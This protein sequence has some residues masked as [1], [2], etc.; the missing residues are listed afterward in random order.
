MAAPRLLPPEPRLFVDRVDEFVALDQALGDALERG[1]PLLAVRTGLPGVGKTTLAVKWAYHVRDRFPDGQLYYELGGSVEPGPVPASDVLRDILVQLGVDEER[2]PHHEHER[3]AVV[4]SLT[5]DKRILLVLDDAFSAAQVMALLPSS[6][7]C[8]VVVTSRKWLDDPAWAYVDRAVLEP[9]AAEFATELLNEASGLDL[10]AEE[11][12][13]KRLVSACAG[14]PLALEVVAG[15][16]RRPRRRIADVVEAVLA[17]KGAVASIE[18]VLDVAYRD[19]APQLAQAYRRLALHPGPDFGVPV[20]AAMLGVPPREGRAQLDEL[21]DVNLLSP[22]GTDRYRFHPLVAAHA[23]DW[24]AAGSTV[25]ECDEVRGRV[26]AWYVDRAISLAR[27]LS[28]RWWT[29]FERFERVDPAFGGPDAAALARRGFQAEHLNLLA[30]L[31]QADDEK[32]HADVLALGDALWPWLYNTDRSVDLDLVQRRAVGAA[33]ALGDRV[34]VMRMRNQFGSAFEMRG[35]LAEAKHE[36]RT[37]LEIARELQHVLGQ[38]SNLEWLGILLEQE[39]E[40]R[41]ALEHLEASA[42]A[43]RQIEDP[44]QRARAMALGAMH[45]GRVLVKVGHFTEAIPLSQN[46]MAYFTEHSDDVNKA[47]CLDLLGRAELGL[48]RPAVAR[49]LAEQAV[50]VSAES[51]PLSLHIAALRTLADV[52]DACGD[53]VAATLHRAQAAELS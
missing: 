43:A 8:A 20:A 52:E 46:A 39:G 5:A 17:G 23:R 9:L 11:A 15:Q 38:Q 33:E 26:V 41:R 14:L 48:G 32:K 2:V 18:T 50:E 35:E 40:L 36:F 3:A 25:A 12:A 44:V 13:V 28:Q 53:E 51:G 4:R 24:S 34:A 47:R 6:P 1:V 27:S 37:S 49:L 31:L 10:G 30:A 7:T 42:D 21:V 29:D 45:T 19:L 16:L 22:V